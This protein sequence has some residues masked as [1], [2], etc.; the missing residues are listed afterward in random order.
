MFEVQ[1][2]EAGGLVTEFQV[3]IE[4]TA[5]KA[6]D[7]QESILLN[8]DCSGQDVNVE[9]IPSAGLHLILGPEPARNLADDQWQF[10]PWN[11]GRAIF[12]VESQIMYLM[13]VI[14]ALE[15]SRRSEVVLC[16]IT[17]PER[18]RNSDVIFDLNPFPG[19]K[20]DH[21]GRKPKAF[22]T[23][24]LASHCL[25]AGGKGGGNVL[26]L[27]LSPFSSGIKQHRHHL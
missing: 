20:V 12:I 21:C 6:F 3:K 5:R 7:K 2:F 16:V 9:R 4:S 1:H 26:N 11:L 13:R 8:S 24:N 17:A 10:S 27:R 25:L 14:T 18:L 15:R 19:Q 22:A 23:A